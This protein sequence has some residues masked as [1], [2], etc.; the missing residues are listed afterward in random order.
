ML[1]EVAAAETQAAEAL[2][3]NVNEYRWIQARIAEASTPAV[4]VDAAAILKAIEAASAKS[5]AQ[6][7]KTA[8]AERGIVPR[9]A[10]DAAVVAHNRTVLEPFRAELAALEQASAHQGV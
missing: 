10:P 8:E 5:G 1:T 3:Q 7:Q 6:L 9:S 4:S 2:G